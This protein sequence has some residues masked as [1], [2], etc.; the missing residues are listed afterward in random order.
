MYPQKAEGQY[1]GK[2]H[3]HHNANTD[4]GTNNVNTDVAAVADVS[5]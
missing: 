5:R 2:T 1:T 4:T 3:Q